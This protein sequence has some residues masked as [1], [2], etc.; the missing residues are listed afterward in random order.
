MERFLIIIGVIVL[1]YICCKILNNIGR[2]FDKTPL[3]QLCRSHLKKTIDT[4]GG[5]K[6]K[7][8]DIPDE[9][10]DHLILPLFAI[11][12]FEKNK[13]DQY[14]MLIPHLDELSIILIFALRHGWV[15]GLCKDE[16]LEELSDD[17]DGLG[18]NNV[19]FIL[20][21]LENYSIIKKCEYIYSSCDDDAYNVNWKQ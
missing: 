17:F 1:T 5:E 4:T 11:L 14:K 9:V 19:E 16:I 8:T 13:L 3:I 2:I 7:H 10:Y 20:D 21:R 12:N 6:I 15:D 18:I